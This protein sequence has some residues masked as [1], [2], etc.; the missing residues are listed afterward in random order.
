MLSNILHRVA[1]LPVWA[2]TLLVLATLLGLGLSVLLS[3]LVMVLAFLVLIVAILGLIVRLLMRRPLRRWGILAA[4]S[5]VVLVV[6]TGISNALYLG[7]QPE[8]SSSPKPQKATEKRTAK[9]EPL[10]QAEKREGVED[11]DQQQAEQ[12]P[13]EVKKEEATSGVEQLPSNGTD[14]EKSDTASSP[15]VKITRVVDG[16]TIEISPAVDGE[17][18]VRLIGIDA[19]ES[20]EP[21]CGPQP[22]AQEAADHAA[23]WE[24]LRVKLEFDEDRTDQYGRLL[25]YVHDPVIDQM[26]NVDMIESGYAQVYIVPPNTK[27]EDELRK[28]QKEAK[29]LSLGFG[30][31]TWSLPPAKEAQLADHG[32]G[33]GQGDGACPPKP[34]PEPQPTATASPNASPNQ[35]Y[36]DPNAPN[37]NPPAT[38][39]ST[40]P[41]TATS[42]VGGGSSASDRLNNGIDDVNCSDLAGPIPTPAGDEDNLDSNDDGTACE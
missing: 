39:A 20:K 23:L 28:A 29:E 37:P 3:P 18:T 26:M 30:L 2:K 5:L 40:A 7:G 17:D 19:P 8:Q 16:D 1:V 14:E 34:Q 31:D 32:N 22:L 42:G 35:D 24:G 15:T 21:G 41:A 38:A 4:T 27:H 11:V 12:P 33:I 9:P 36:N 13:Q 25:A 6:F 10:E